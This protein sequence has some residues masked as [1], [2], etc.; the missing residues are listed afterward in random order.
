MR[1]RREKKGHKLI[2]KHVEI[3]SLYIRFEN[4][5]KYNILSCKCYYFICLLFDSKVKKKYN[6]VNYTDH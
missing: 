6:K 3:L 2:L 5:E 4:L 1:I